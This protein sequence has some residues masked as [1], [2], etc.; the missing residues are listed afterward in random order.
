[1]HECTRYSKIFFRFDRVNEKFPQDITCV[2]KCLLLNA[3][4]IPCVRLPPR[5]RV[6]HGMVPSL[7]FHDELIRN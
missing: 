6:M 3:Y 1:V 2:C 7:Q 5:M 4:T